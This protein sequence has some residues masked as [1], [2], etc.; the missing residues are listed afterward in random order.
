MATNSLAHYFNTEPELQVE[1]A[2]SSDD[3]S[4]N[5]DDMDPAAAGAGGDDDDEYVSP[6]RKNFLWVFDPVVWHIHS[7][8]IHTHIHSQARLYAA[9]K[10][11]KTAPGKA[12]SS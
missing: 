4:D 5:A 8:R 2:A 10:N 1:E 3:E 9:E 11:C 6:Q 12:S 7:Q